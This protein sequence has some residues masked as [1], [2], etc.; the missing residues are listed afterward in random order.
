MVPA[1]GPCHSIP[2]KGTIVWHKELA[3]IQIWF[4]LW[5]NWYARPR[6]CLIVDLGL[7]KEIW[8]PEGIYSDLFSKCQ[9]MCPVSNPQMSH[10]SEY[11][12]PVLHNIGP[13][14][15]AGMVSVV[16][17]LYLKTYC[18][19]KFCNLTRIYEYHQLEMSRVWTWGKFNA[20][21]RK[22]LLWKDILLMV[23]SL[24][25]WID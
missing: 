16:I 15:F 7:D 19:L 20:L 17:N 3:I 22:G 10:L 24:Y 2:H 6:P 14:T 4:Q 8:L 12:N 1:D 13:W 11:P 18:H 21:L 9:S 25:I 23:E 5:I